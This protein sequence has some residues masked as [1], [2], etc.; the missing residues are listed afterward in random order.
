MAQ[1]PFAGILPVAAGPLK[2]VEVTPGAVA[3]VAPFKGK[4]AAVDK[5]L[6]KH[7]IGFPDAGQAIEGPHAAAIWTGIDECFLL[8]DAPLSL[9]L[10]GKA[11]VTD[12]SDGWGW[13][14]LSGDG[15]QDVMARLCPVD[16]AAM[17]PGCAVRSEAAHMMAIIYGVRDGVV[18][19]VMRSFA[20]TMAH[21]ISVAMTSVA[22]QKEME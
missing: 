1:T 19:G 3:S 12:Q 13:V 16:P 9:N 21:D 6:A 20:R 17:E 7:A 18:I 14:R 5:A 2:A 10:S 11:A 4:A 15:W 8:S 22:T